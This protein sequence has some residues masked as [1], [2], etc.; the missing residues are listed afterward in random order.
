MVKEQGLDKAV[1]ENGSG[2]AGGQIQREENDRALLSGQPSLLAYEAT[3]ALD[4]NLSLGIHKTLLKNPRIAVIEVAHK[5]S[6]E[7][8]AM[9]DVIIHLDTHTIETKM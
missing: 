9:F 2:M 6:P 4:P 5:I 8:K 7:E 1:G 3:S